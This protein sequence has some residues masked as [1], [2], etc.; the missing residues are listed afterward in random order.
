MQVARDLLHALLLLIT[1]EAPGGDVERFPNETD[2]LHPNSCSIIGPLTN[3]QP[4]AI[5]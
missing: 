1:F 4:I 5:F 3:V 2:D